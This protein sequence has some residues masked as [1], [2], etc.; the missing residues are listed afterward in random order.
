MGVPNTSVNTSSSD[1]PV[2]GAVTSSTSWPS[3]ASSSAAPLTA[4]SQSG[5]SGA[6]VAAV[7][8]QPIRSRPGSWAAVAANGSGGGGA[9]VASPG[10]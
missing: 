6:S 10:S 4:R 2:Q 8:V 9:Q 7:V 3:D 1:W 5:S